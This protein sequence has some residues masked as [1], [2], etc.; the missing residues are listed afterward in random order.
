MIKKKILIGPAGIIMLHYHVDD[1][2]IYDDKSLGF[3]YQEHLLRKVFN[4]EGSDISLYLIYQDFNKSIGF[5]GDK[6]YPRDKEYAEGKKTLSEIEGSQGSKLFMRSKNIKV[7]KNL[8]WKPILE[9]YCNHE[10]WDIEY[11]KFLKTLPY[12][13]KVFIEFKYGHIKDYESWNNWLFS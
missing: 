2:I 12:Y 4:E 8:H 3:D 6:I 1:M 9:Y 10:Y 13:K 5:G 7:K 11:N